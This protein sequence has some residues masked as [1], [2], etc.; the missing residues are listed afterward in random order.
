MYFAHPFC[1]F[2]KYFLNKDI[3]SYQLKQIP[4]KII[5]EAEQI[6]IASLVKKIIDLHKENDIEEALLLEKEID[7]IVYK[8]YDLSAEEIAMVESECE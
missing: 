4:V 3:Y 8:L 6:A 2:L 1:L 5:S 7:A